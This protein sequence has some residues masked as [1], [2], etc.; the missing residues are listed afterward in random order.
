MPTEREDPTSMSKLLAGEYERQWYSKLSEMKQQQQPKHILT[1]ENLLPEAG[2][3]KYASGYQ[4]QEKA[5]A[6]SGG[7]HRKRTEDEEEE[8]KELFKLNRFKSIPSK[9]DPYQRSELLAAVK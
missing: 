8:Q 9:L 1:D 5:D 7:L 2:M 3:D 4:R 6:E